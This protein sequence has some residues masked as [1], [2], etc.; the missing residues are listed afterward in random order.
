[1]PEDAPW[2]RTFFERDYYDTFYAPL[3]GQSGRLGAEHTERE[4]DFIVA[5]LE[6]K[7]GARVLDLACGHGRHS[8]ALAKRGYDVTGLDISAYHI[9]LAQQAASD[10]GVRATFICDDMRNLP[11]EPPF[12][13]IFNYFTAFGY[14]ESDDEDA[15]V[16]ERV[17]RALKPGGRFLIETNNT[18]RT[19]RHWERS[20]VTRL[21]DGSLLLEER[22]FDVL[23]GRI[24]GTLTHVSPTGERKTGEIHPRAYTPVELA[25]MF[26]RA[27]LHVVA[28][29]GDTD[30]SP[31][32]MD[33]R[34]MALVGEKP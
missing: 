25:R 4:A 18:L 7:P 13:A 17:A 15:A 12:D 23:A 22:E 11:L 21:D 10:A 1:M 32:T 29:Y 8:I 26:E 24:D 16:V 33:S 3:L 20:S 30:R 28:S 14:L 9:E 31:L 6:L 34:R 5:A 19:L 2:Y 27:G